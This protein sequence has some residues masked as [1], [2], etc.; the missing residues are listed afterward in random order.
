MPDLV[1][2]G[3]DKMI[4]SSHNGQLGHEIAGSQCPRPR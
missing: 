4:D 2:N 3:A 1:V